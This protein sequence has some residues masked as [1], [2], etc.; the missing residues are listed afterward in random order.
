MGRISAP[1]LVVFLA[2]LAIAC[3]SGS[4]TLQLRTGPIAEDAFRVQVRQTAFINPAIFDIACGF[5]SPSANPIPTPEFL[6][7]FQKANPFATVVSPLE[8]HS[9]DEE[10]AVEIIAEECESLT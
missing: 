7:A 10:R 3:S 9:A 2:V 4:P 6:E 1:Y 5:F 8:V